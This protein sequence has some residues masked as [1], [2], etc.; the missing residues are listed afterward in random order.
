MNPNSIETFTTAIRYLTPEICVVTAILFAGLWNLFVPK[1]KDVTPWVSM[2]LLVAACVFLSQQF[3]M[4]TRLLFQGLF[5]VDKLRAAFGLLSCLVG[6]IV[7]FMS[8]G[9]ERHFGNNVGEFYAILL[10]AV[11]S[12][13]VLAGATDLIFL[14]VGLETLTICCV[15]LSGFAKRDRKSNE[16]SLKYLLSTA[17]TTAT[18]LYGLTFIYGLTGSTNYGEIHSRIY[19]FVQSPSLVVIFAMVLLLSAV[20]FKLSMVPFHMWTPDVYEGAPTPVTAYLSVGSKLGGFA[21]AVRLLMSLFDQAAPDWS[22]ILAFLAVLSMIIG[23]FVALAQTS[24]KRMLAY[25]S[26]AHVGYLLIGLVANSNEGL[27]ALV[28]YFIVYGFM[29]LGAFAGAILFASETGSDSIDDFAGLVRKRPWL[30]VCMSIC[31][32]NLA[33]LPVPPAGFLAKLFVFW[34]GFQMYSTTG[35][36]LVAAALIT[37]VPAVYYYSRVVIMMIVK[38][39]SPKVQAMADTRPRLAD[40]PNGPS[41]ALALSILGITAGSFMVNQLMDFSGKAVS[42]LGKAPTMSA[43]PPTTH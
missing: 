2:G 7:I 11:L 22:V 30:A 27:T 18:F 24:F 14:F 21:V 42:S 37:S 8:M 13:M 40:S 32:L 5:T 12:V 39:P 29:N 6:I 3:G 15:L 20:G 4:E 16:A 23:N 28:F 9:Y 10:T 34:S 43:L 17:A 31:L 25:S 35:Y 36:I 33:G 19:P 26:I 1:Q 38:D 41:I